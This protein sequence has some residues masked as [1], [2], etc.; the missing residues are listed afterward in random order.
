MNKQTNWAHFISMQCGIVPHS[1][2]SPGTAKT[3]LHAALA[4]QTN[5]YFVQSIL[6]QKMPEDLGGIPQPEMILTDPVCVKGVRYLLPEEMVIA[7]HKP[8]IV[9]LDELNHAGHDVLG[10]AQ[11]WINNVPKNCWMAACS[12]PVE[13]STAGQELSLP[14]INRMVTLEWETP[15]EVIYSGWQSGFQSYDEFDFPIVP[16]DYL[17]TYGQYWG[18]KLIQFDREQPDVLENDM[19]K[20]DEIRPYASYRSLTNMGKLM[21]ACD[22]VGANKGTRSKIVHGTI[23]RNAGQAFLELIRSETLPDPEDLLK[24]PKSLQL[25]A[26]FDRVRAIIQSVISAVKGTN[27]KRWEQAFDVLEVAFEQNQEAAMAAEGALWKAKPAGH[28]PVLRKDG[29]AKAMRDLR[30]Q[31]A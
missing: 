19:P 28:E 14:A 10:A 25:P 17:A 18:E 15:T 5:R 27:G 26:R 21:A 1:L 13:H 23:G 24:D 3:A 16:A 11:E 2:G 8:S 12:N 22:A 20:D 4:A 30:L 6:R 7:K 29:A 9:L 31:M